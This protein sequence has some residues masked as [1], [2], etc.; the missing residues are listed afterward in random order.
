MC[1][2]H[3]ASCPY[4]RTYPESLAARIVA[5]T[6]SPGRC[7]EPGLL[8]MASSKKSSILF[9]TGATCFPERARWLGPAPEPAL[10]NGA[11]LVRM[12]A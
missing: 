1:H 9:D 11:F 3:Q 5:E 8:A 6:K 2:N 7:C 12:A 4:G 10:A